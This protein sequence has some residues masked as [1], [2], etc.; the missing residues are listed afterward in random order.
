MIMELQV[1]LNHIAIFGQLKDWMIH[2]LNT[3]EDCGPLEEL[4][5]FM[6]DAKNA[7]GI[8]IAAGATA[9]TEFGKHN[10]LKKVMKSSFMFIMH[11]LIVLTIL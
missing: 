10:F 6:F 7:K 9:Y 4:T 11:T 5:Q 1:Q 2:K 8:L 3:Q